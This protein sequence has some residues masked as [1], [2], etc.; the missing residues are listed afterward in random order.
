MTLRKETLCFAGFL[1]LK[2]G[3]IRAFDTFFSDFQFDL[4]CV[5]FDLFDFALKRSKYLRFKFDQNQI[6][7]DFLKFGFTVHLIH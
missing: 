3:Q 4:F 2:I 5:K 6:I 1:R 7:N